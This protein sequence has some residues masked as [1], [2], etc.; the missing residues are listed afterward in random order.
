MKLESSAFF[1]LSAMTPYRSALLLFLLSF[2]IYTATAKCFRDPRVNCVSDCLSC[3]M[4]GEE[5]CL[6]GAPIP[7]GIE[8]CCKRCKIDMK[9]L[10]EGN[11]FLVVYGIGSCRTKLITTPKSFYACLYE[12]YRE[13]RSMTYKNFFNEDCH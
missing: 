12:Y 5:R 2:H 1:Q 7:T 4:I 6:V 10:P 8:D 13:K 9:E 3:V 11:P